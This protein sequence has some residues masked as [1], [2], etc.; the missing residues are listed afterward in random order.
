M[1][2][3]VM[4]LADGCDG[5]GGGGSCCCEFDGYQRT[6]DPIASVCLR[7]S[8]Y[9]NTTVPLMILLAGCHFNGKTV[10][11]GPTT[12]NA[13]YASFSRGYAKGRVSEGQDSMQ[14]FLR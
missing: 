3:E 4:V 10:G 9:Y 5:G 2:V 14:A 12:I 7:T 8:C 6:F 1:E 13:K 11:L